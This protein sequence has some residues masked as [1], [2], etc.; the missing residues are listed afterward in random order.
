MG[1]KKKNCFIFLIYHVLQISVSDRFLNRKAHSQNLLIK[2]RTSK[3]NHCDLA[4]RVT[5]V[6]PAPHAPWRRGKSEVRLHSHPAPRQQDIAI[7][8]LLFV[9]CSE[10]ENS[11]S[12]FLNTKW[13][14]AAR[15]NIPSEP[16]PRLHRRQGKQKLLHSFPKYFAGRRPRATPLACFNILSLRQKGGREGGS[17]QPGMPA[18]LCW[19]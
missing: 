2:H 5:A 1:N 12:C 7:R 9:P 6:L 10:Q 16:T 14:R 8:C 3:E 18:L 13:V 17:C 11:L 15:A 19:C 4:C